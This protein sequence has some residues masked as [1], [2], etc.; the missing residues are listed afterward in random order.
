MCADI[1]R[2]T[3]EKSHIWKDTLEKSG[4]TEVAVMCADGASGKVVATAA[5]LDEV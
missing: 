2:N 1:G 5:L 3:V 4:Q